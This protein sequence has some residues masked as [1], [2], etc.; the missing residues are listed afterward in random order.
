MFGWWP[1]ISS[2]SLANRCHPKRIHRI[3]HVQ[4]RWIE[5]RRAEWPC[6]IEPGESDTF[7]NSH[8]KHRIA[9]DEHVDHLEHVHSSLDFKNDY[10]TIAD[11]SNTT[12]WAEKIYIQSTLLRV[13]VHCYSICVRVVYFCIFVFSAWTRTPMTSGMPATKKI[14][15]HANRI[16]NRMRRVSALGQTSLSSSNRVEITASTTGNYKQKKLSFDVNVF[17]TCQYCWSSF[18]LLI[19]IL[20]NYRIFKQ[21]VYSEFNVQVN[22]Q[23]EL[24]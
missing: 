10:W 21:I 13:G 7:E 2:K 20:K 23:R 14:T 5:Y 3:C 24:I 18:L 12:D 4:Q 6:T 19:W 15:K 1:H 9:R 16:M 11:K 8:C 17:I 22:N